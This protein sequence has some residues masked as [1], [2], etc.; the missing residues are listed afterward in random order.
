MAK[1][2]TERQLDVLDAIVA[3]SDKHDLPPTSCAIAE[4]LY[5]SRHTVDEHIDELVRKELIE[6]RQ[7]EADTRMVFHIRRK[8]RIARNADEG[9][10]DQIHTGDDTLKEQVLADFFAV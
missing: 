5:V 2:P 1:P 3:Y 7:R 10:E 8:G 6:P 4:L 9:R